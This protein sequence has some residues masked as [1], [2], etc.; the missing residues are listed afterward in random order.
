VDPLPEPLLFK[1]AGRA[2]NRNLGPL[3]LQPGTLITTPQ[4]RSTGELKDLKCDVTELN[5]LLN[6]D[7]RQSV[8]EVILTEVNI[9]SAQIKVWELLDN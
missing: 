4:R 3:G 8:K 9:I 1:R 6:T 5:Q 2:G 7:E